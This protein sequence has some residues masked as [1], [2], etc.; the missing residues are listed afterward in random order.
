MQTRK[1]ETNLKSR[2]EKETIHQSPILRHPL[3]EASLGREVSA[4]PLPRISS[5][6]AIPGVN[7]DTSRSGGNEALREERGVAVASQME[8]KVLVRL[9][10]GNRRFTVRCFVRDWMSGELFVGMYCFP[11]CFYVG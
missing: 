11:V 5:S 4:T 8:R 1:Q 9:R 6:S 10:D 7:A 3:T 2:K